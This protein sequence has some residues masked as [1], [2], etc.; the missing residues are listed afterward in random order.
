MKRFIFGQFV[1]G[2]AI[3]CTIAVVMFALYGWLG[4]LAYLL[5]AG[6]CLTPAI[7]KARSILKREKGGGSR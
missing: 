1:F 7:L 5:V 6:L 3:I 2:G 4:A